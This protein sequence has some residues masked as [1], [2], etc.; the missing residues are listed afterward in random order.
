MSDRRHGNDGGQASAAAVAA[1]SPPPTRPP[2]RPSDAATA[3]S[4]ARSAT[5]LTTQ[6][7]QERPRGSGSGKSSLAFGTLYAEAQRRHQTSEDPALRRRPILV[8]RGK[9]S[10][11]NLPRRRLRLRRA[12][13]PT[14]CL[15]T[16]P[17]LQGRTLQRQDVGNKGPR[18]V[19]RRC[20]GYDGRCRFRVLCR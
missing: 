19:C 20:P 4:T 9:G 15:R 8:Q 11:R 6:S 1:R 5:R 18:Q 16:L 3:M 7:R 17:H 12:F 10:L 14:Q 2:P 13:V